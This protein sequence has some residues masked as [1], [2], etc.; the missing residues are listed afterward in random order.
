MLNVLV[1]DD[2]LLVAQAVGGLLSELCDLGLDAVCGSAR[3]ALQVL[4]QSKPDLLVQDLHLPGESWETVAQEF[5]RR[6]PA[7]KVL[8]LTA[9]ADTF[10][11][12]SWLG[13][14]LLGVVDK[15]RAWSDLISVVSGWRRQTL[16]AQALS[17]AS[18][19]LPAIDALSPREQRVFQCLGQGLLNREVAAELGLSVGT[20]ESYR[21]SICSK[22]GIS[23]SELVRLAVLH[24][25]LPAPA[26]FPGAG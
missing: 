9:L 18:R 5:L 15:S 21:K 1:V 8:I 3:Q 6:N 23:G 13:L 4:E 26:P 10:E 7:G 25:C 14:S 17:L 24:R 19:T 12:P 2:H 20:V 22:L 11:P 16:P